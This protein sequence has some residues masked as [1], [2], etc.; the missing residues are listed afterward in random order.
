MDK[1]N[2]MLIRMQMKANQAVEEFKDSERGDTNFVSMLLIIGVV[3]VLAGLF[4]TLGKE[5][6]NEI[7]NKVKD[8]IK[9]L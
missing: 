1:L 9:G 7:T 8:F 6:M 2:G 5:V 4:L 3:V